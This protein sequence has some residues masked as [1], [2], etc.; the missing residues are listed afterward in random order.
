MHLKNIT[1][2]LT[3]TVP[4]GTIC[5]QVVIQNLE[6]H[7]NRNVK[8]NKICHCVLT[9]SVHC[10]RGDY[11]HCTDVGRFF[12]VQYDQNTR[13]ISF[14]LKLKFILVFLNADEMSKR[15]L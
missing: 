8:A 4:E 5:S 9:V 12:H 11:Q 2:D 3:K 13:A 6:G 14:S 7:D 10:I 1:S 15:V